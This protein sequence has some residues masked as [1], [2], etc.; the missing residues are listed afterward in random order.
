MLV[1]QTNHANQSTQLPKY[2]QRMMFLF[3]ISTFLLLLE[4][5][6]LCQN[7]EFERWK[8]KILDHKYDCKFDEDKAKVDVGKPIFEVIECGHKEAIC[9]YDFKVS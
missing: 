1:D 6:V 7:D 9:N 8:K 2:T 4:C 5:Y 3:N